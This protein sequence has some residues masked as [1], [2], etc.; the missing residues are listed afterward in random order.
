[1]ADLLWDELPQRWEGRPVRADFRPM[2]WM[3][4]QILRGAPDKDPLGFL[5]ELCRRFYCVPV[6][7]ADLPQAWA[8]VQR[9]YAGGT[10]SGTSSAGAD[11]DSSSELALDYQC[12]A[13]YIVAAFQKAYGIDLT[14]EKVHWWRFRALLT[15]ILAQPDEYLLA[16][17]VHYRITDPTDL[18]ENERERCQRIR[19]HYALP[20][21]LRGGAARAVTVAE[22]DAAFFARFRR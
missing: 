12:D 16:R 5:R 7:D 6:A 18:P 9:F 4:S 22:H 17:I 15:G 2:C 19:Q 13:P 14:K 10:P 20:P 1:M 11:S 8:A 3:I 21:E